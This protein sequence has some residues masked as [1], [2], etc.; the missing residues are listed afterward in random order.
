MCCLSKLVSVKVNAL[1]FSLKALC[2]HTGHITPHFGSRCRLV[3]T[4]ASFSKHS[5]PLSTTLIECTLIH[6]QTLAGVSAVLHHQQSSPQEKT[7]AFFACSS[8]TLQTGMLNTTS[9]KSL[10]C[11]VQGSQNLTWGLLVGWCTFYIKWI[12]QPYILTRNSYWCMTGLFRISEQLKT[13]VLLCMFSELLMPEVI[14][15]ENCRIKDSVEQ[16]NGMSQQGKAE[17]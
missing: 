7:M 14:F 6:A 10:V 5:W 1:N 8:G 9:T 12:L 16:V 2:N 3:M 11:L 4:R 13:S 15:L 17:F